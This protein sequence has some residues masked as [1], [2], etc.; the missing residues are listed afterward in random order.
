MVYSLMP[1]VPA[2]CLPSIL[3]TVETLGHCRICCHDF[4]RPLLDYLPGI[5]VYH[6]NC[7]CSELK[8]KFLRHRSHCIHFDRNAVV[9]Q[10]QKTGE[11]FFKQCP[12]QVL[13][14]VVPIRRGTVC[15]GVL[16]LGPFRGLE[17]LP[18]GSLCGTSRLDEKLRREAATLYDRLP[19]LDHDGR[20]RLLDLGRLLAAYLSSRLPA[21]EPAAPAEAPER[22]RRIE[23]YLAD[24]FNRNL[25]LDDLAEMLG[26]SASRTSR[27]LRE[28]FRCGFPELL[29]RQRLRAACHLLERS[30][31]SAQEVARRVGF[32]RPEHFHRLF[33]KTCGLTPLAYRR[34]HRAGEPLSP[35][36]PAPAAID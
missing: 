3:Q 11:P 30:E 22:R 23:R 33:R 21:P 27:L 36:A 28:H 34:R 16:F 9:R 6:R 10:L 25:T 8:K 13:E 19:E 24:N 35:A 2:N 7:F 4:L 1:T 12:Y 26:L 5:P 29:N 18:P 14:L 20:T 15:Y 31:L 17:A 32:A